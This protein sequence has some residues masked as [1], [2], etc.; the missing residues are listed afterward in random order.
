[1]S[2]RST[3]QDPKPTGDDFGSHVS[4]PGG[5][6]IGI[7]RAQMNLFFYLITTA[8]AKS[9]APSAS[10]FLAAAGLRVLFLFYFD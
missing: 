9:F 8:P 7:G 4:L 10:V 2:R 5:V 3:W 1:V 6:S